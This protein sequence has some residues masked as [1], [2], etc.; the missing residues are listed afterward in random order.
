MLMDN[1]PSKRR[2]TSHTTSLRISG[3]T[4][5][6]PQKP[7]REPTRSTPRRKSFQ[8][9]TKASLARFNP[10][11]LARSS[12]S[13]RLSS[14]RLNELGNGSSRTSLPFSPPRS[15]VSGESQRTAET[16]R[17][18]AKANATENDNLHH[19]GLQERTPDPSV[20]AEQSQ[21]STRILDTDAPDEP[22]PPRPQTMSRRQF[23]SDPSNRLAPIANMVPSAGSKAITIH[24][25]TPKRLAPVAPRRS[26]RLSGGK[27]HDVLSDRRDVAE[28]GGEPDLPP[29]LMDMGL[30][31]PHTPGGLSQASTPRKKRR[32]EQ[33]PSSSTPARR[34]VIDQVDLE[35]SRSTRDLASTQDRE[36]VDIA[37]DAG[38]KEDLK[39]QL[40]SELRQLEE[41]VVTLENELSRAESENRRLREKPPDRQGINEP[42]YLTKTAQRPIVEA[43]KFTVKGSQLSWGAFL[44]FAK[45]R[46]P[47]AAAPVLPIPDGPPP[48]H[49]PIDLDDPLPY[50]QLFTPLTFTSTSK[51]FPSSA[52]AVNS[53]RAEQQHVIKATSP[54]HLLTASMALTVDIATHTITALSIASLSGWAERELG[55]WIRSRAD[56]SNVAGRDISSICWAI[57]RYWELAEKRARY[58]VRCEENHPELLLLAFSGDPSTVLKTGGRHQSHIALTSGENHGSFEAMRDVIEAAFRGM[59]PGPSSSTRRRQISRQLGR[60][61]LS[62]CREDVQLLITWTI[63]FDWTGD[64]HSQVTAVASMPEAWT[65]ADSRASLAKIPKLFRDLVAEKGVSRATEIIVGL[66]FPE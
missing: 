4:T 65:R 3:P 63:S 51:L 56:S 43:S 21:E 27:S 39:R 14:R 40:L 66:L 13:A 60:S 58:M 31:E 24:F 20:E 15:S 8:S 2:R 37:N 33:K 36:D 50:L 10:E 32:P 23:V 41:E 1:N 17:Q 28:E 18:V 57:G 16:S 29:T 62:F 49:Y 52:T 53:N 54:E 64:T 48:S 25:P 45:R 9:P 38:I 11:L 12:Q 55:K 46:K 19:T 35:E 47:V 61:S 22:L 44:P 34:A 5:P 26:A 7:R 6:S 30:D 42:I 59:Q